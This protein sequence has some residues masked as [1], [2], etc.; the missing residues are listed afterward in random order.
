MHFNAI[1][2]VGQVSGL[3]SRSIDDLPIDWPTSSRVPIIAEHE[4]AHYPS[5]VSVFQAPTP[6]LLSTN[7][8]SFEYPEADLF[9]CPLGE[10][11]DNRVSEF[12]ARTP[13]Y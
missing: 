5:M 9:E 11:V 10:N 3:V 12:I 8:M 2:Q 1:P 4:E 7:S 6:F 13:T